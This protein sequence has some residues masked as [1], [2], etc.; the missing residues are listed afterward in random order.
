MKNW[1]GK[2]ILYFLLGFVTIV[3]ATYI[4][5]IGH[6]EKAMMYFGDSIQLLIALFAGISIMALFGQ[7]SLQ[8]IIHITPWKFVGIGF[9]AWAI[10][11]IYW[12]YMEIVKGVDMGN[13]NILYSWADIGF[14]LLYPL[15][16]IGFITELRSLPKRKVP[17]LW[18]LAILLGFT[19]LMVYLTW[20]TLV[21]TQATNTI[22][23][24]IQLCYLVGD[25][26][27][28]IGAAY[29]AW[30]TRGGIISAAWSIL[31]ASFAFFAFGNQFYNFFS[32]IEGNAYKT[33]NLI[34]L[35]WIV[36]FIIA[37]VGANVFHTML[38][39]QS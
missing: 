33:G 26:V 19:A 27:I 24:I 13:P 8:E 39:E 9:I 36:A 25:I 10:G 11:Q 16:I 5:L 18:V 17:P 12:S 31:A 34:D 28:V 38:R 30:Q 29:I 35:T 6:D 1:F 32:N 2:N 21:Y 3:I 23:F 37:W 4:Y 22:Q 20:G 14:L 7:R 15:V